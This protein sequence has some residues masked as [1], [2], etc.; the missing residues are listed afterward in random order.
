M[1]GEEYKVVAERLLDV[2]R[3]APR[4]PRRIPRP[5]TPPAD[6]SGVWDTDIEYEVGSAR[7]KLFLR[8]N[9]NA[10]SGSYSGWACEGDL[11]GTID[12]S[13]VDLRS[14]LPAEGTQLAYRFTGTAEATTC[15]AK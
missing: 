5:A 1:K 13:R 14:S 15:R 4:T 10:L 6:I 2:F 9:G 12:G 3:S 11:T 8:A 7:H